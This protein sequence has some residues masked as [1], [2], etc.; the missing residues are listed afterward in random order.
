[1]CVLTIAK[2]TQFYVMLKYGNRCGYVSA[3]IFVEKVTVY[4]FKWLALQRTELFVYELFFYSNSTIQIFALAY[5]APWIAKRFFSLLVFIVEFLQITWLF[6]CAA[7][8]EGIIFNVTDGGGGSE[9]AW[10]KESEHARGEY[11]LHLFCACVL[12]CNSQISLKLLKFNF[13]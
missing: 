7:L 3:F 2:V 11:F 13:V 5:R 6:I 4:R 10:E 8:C 12:F 1:M 9:R